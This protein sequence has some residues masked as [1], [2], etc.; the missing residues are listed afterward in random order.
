KDNLCKERVRGARMA[1]SEE[2]AYPSVCERRATQPAGM[3][4]VGEGE[5]C[6]PEPSR[7]VRN[8]P[9]VPQSIGRAPARVIFER[10]LTLAGWRRDGAGRFRASALRISALEPAGWLPIASI[11]VRL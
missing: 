5:L 7:E 10:R 6:S 9:G 2:R 3:D 11:G 4:R 8:P 1:R